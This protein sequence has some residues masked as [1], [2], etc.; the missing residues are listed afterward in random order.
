MVFKYHEHDSL[1]ESNSEQDLSEEEKADAWAAYENDVKIRN[2][3]SNMGTYNPN[4]QM[5]TG[6]EGFSPYASMYNFGTSYGANP[7][8][9]SPYFPQMSSYST[10]LMRMYESYLYS[11]GNASSSTAAAATAAKNLYSSVGNS[12]MAS[13]PASTSPA[14]SS[15]NSLRNLLHM[16][17]SVGGYSNANGA[18]L[19]PMNAASSSSSKNYPSQMMNSSSAMQM[20]LNSLQ[21]GPMGAQSALPGSKSSSAASASLYDSSMH[22]YLQQFGLLDSVVPT[23]AAATASNSASVSSSNATTANTVNSITKRNPMLS[24]E[25]SIPSV[26]PSRPPSM[27]ALVMAGNQTSVITKSALSSNTPA[28]PLLPNSA[29][30]LTSTVVS[31]AN[32]SISMVSTKALTSVSTP[33]PGS[34]K[35]NRKEKTNSAVEPQIP[36]GN[37]KPAEKPKTPIPIPVSISRSNSSASLPTK[38]SSQPA[39]G[40]SDSP[41]V[42]TNF[43]IF[44]PPVTKTVATAKPSIS[45]VSPKTGNGRTNTPTMNESS[46]KAFAV[47]NKGK[48][49][50]V[51]PDSVDNYSCSSSSAR[52]A[53]RHAHKHSEA[54]FADPENS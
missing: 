12:L 18:F 25:L 7:S 8:L 3:M 5:T 1:L 27:D 51:C 52:I 2:Q 45:T 30:P 23:T 54:E 40:A 26:T 20:Y 49:S 35:P 11:Y 34:S 41:A 38:E 10:D 47:V 21:G 36:A 46:N 43:G 16:N 9:M 15:S 13:P 14:A 50:S 39:K 42:T 31:T 29:Q 33:S 28:N 24:K 44:Y 48:S 22:S 19:P 17:A 32:S 37:V 4:L 6:Y 53:E